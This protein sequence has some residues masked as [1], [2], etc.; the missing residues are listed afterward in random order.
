MHVE[1]A[2]EMFRRQAEKHLHSPNV[3]L[4]RFCPARQKESVNTEYHHS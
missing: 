3:T 1:T 4:P 2:T